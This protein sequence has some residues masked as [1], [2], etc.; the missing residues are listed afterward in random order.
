M[1]ATKR[2]CLSLTSLAA[3][4]AFSAN[5]LAADITWRAGAT[6]SPGCRRSGEARPP[7]ASVR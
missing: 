6:G 1:N 7:L 4:L 5:A 2:V 3:A